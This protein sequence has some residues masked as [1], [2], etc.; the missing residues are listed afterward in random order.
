MDHNKEQLPA[1][2]PLPEDREI[3][4]EIR[5]EMGR[6]RQNISE[7]SRIPSG[8]EQETE[9]LPQVMPVRSVS[10]V[11]PV[12]NGDEEK[13]TIQPSQPP[14][15]EIPA[16]PL[17][18]PELPQ[19][20]APTPSP[21]VAEAE[22]EEEHPKRKK[23]E[24]KEK[25]EKHSRRKEKKAAKEIA[26]EMENDIY[27]GVRIRS[28]D[29]IKKD[30]E[31]N[32]PKQSEPTSTFTY[33]FDNTAEL[34]EILLSKDPE[35]L[36]RE[37]EERARQ[38]VQDA[39]TELPATN[40]P[41]DTTPIAVDKPLAPEFGHRQAAKPDDR[42][43][44]IDG[45]D[46][47]EWKR[48]TQQFPILTD[49]VLAAHQA[50][51]LPVSTVKP[52]N[53]DVLPVTIRKDSP[54]D[55]D[56]QAL[57]AF[58]E[59]TLSEPGQSSEPPVDAPV[60]T[61]PISSAE[62]NIPSESIP[63]TAEPSVTPEEPKVPEQPIVS[64]FPA[65]DTEPSVEP[66][67]TVVSEPA[68]ET[69]ASVVESATPE[70]PNVP[71]Q[72][73]PI[74]EAPA[75]ISVEPTLD[76]DTTEPA[77]PAHFI[78]VADPERYRFHSIPVRTYRLDHINEMLQ[79]EL[80]TYRD[81]NHQHRP[82]AQV[83][84]QPPVTKEPEN[85]SAYGKVLSLSA[86]AG[87]IEAAIQEAIRQADENQLHQ[88]QEHSSQPEQPSSSE[89][90]IPKAEPPFPEETPV[91][92]AE[93]KEEPVTS[94]APSEPEK[95]AISDA[96]DVPETEEPT[97]EPTAESEVTTEESVVESPAEEQP[98]KPSDE[99]DAQETPASEVIAEQAAVPTDA[100]PAPPA[101][102][103]S[104]KPEEPKA[105]P[106]DNEVTSEKSSSDTTESEEE[107]SSEESTAEPAAEAPAVTATEQPKEESRELSSSSDGHTEVITG[108]SGHT[109]LQ[110]LP[111]IPSLKLPDE[112]PTAPEEPKE[113]IC[114]DFSEQE[115]DPIPAGEEYTPD[116]NPKEISKE[117]RTMT[118]ELQIRT[119]VTGFCTAALL[120]L[121]LIYEKFIPDTTNAIP[122]LIINLVLLVAPAALCFKTIVNGI[123]SLFGLQG[124]TDS[125]IA[126]AVL[127]SIVHGVALFFDSSLVLNGSVH[128]Y[129]S[130]AVGALLLNSIGKLSMTNR[131]A[132]NFIFVTSAET[133]CSVEFYDNINT[134]IQLANGCVTEAPKIAYQKKTKFLKNFLHHSY[135]GDPSVRTSQ[136]I[137]PIALVASVALCIVTIIIT[138]NVLM[139]LTALSVAT[140]I[141][142]PLASLLCVNLPVA[143]LCNL[144]RRHGAMLS[145]YEAVE[146]MASANA[147][148][149]GSID[150]F[151]K[152]SVS[153]SDVKIYH[154]KRTE[155]AIFHAAA[156]MSNIG[157]TLRDLFEGVI[158][159]QK[160]MLPKA[161]D[162]SYI[163]GQGMVGTVNG[164]RL[165]IGTRLMMEENNIQ[166][167]GDDKRLHLKGN[168]C[169]LFLAEDEELMAM[170]TVSYKPDGATV[171]EL[172]RMERCGIAVLVRAL[173]PNLTSAFLTKLFSLH[174]NTIKV[175]PA[176][177]GNYCDEALEEPAESCDAL[178]A[179]RGRTFSMMRMLSACARQKHNISLTV[180]M[181][182]VSVILGFVLV[183]FLSCYAGLQQ[184]S[185][186]AILLYE[187]FWLAA[188]ILIPK[189]RKP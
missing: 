131:I 156:V 153:L 89:Q 173:D 59:Q 188:I 184:L 177:L 39:M 126:V 185:T 53:S 174:E 145:G 38:A 41:I 130:I 105:E 6:L 180:T 164:K 74:V 31:Q 14:Q 61:K 141:S 64:E 99:Q 115:K 129:S 170:L 172:H 68:A 178:L 37:R 66:E 90:E 17:P 132:R 147:V 62:L 22:P 101:E 187:A 167:P 162:I 171:H 5:S 94:P 157:G 154:G 158:T 140:C 47:K 76:V 72:A 103:A 19:T 63:E 69:T 57:E 128:L 55:P 29:E 80:E 139:G 52:T 181:Q 86:G 123:K 30:L 119:V 110:T 134:A 11:R 100:E 95:A 111:P 106:S 20:P 67:P 16:N 87:G 122:Y 65:A 160:E 109:G 73:A 85:Q 44:I 116:S 98:E 118:K 54:L 56:I 148:L 9:A 117:L 43:I 26:D 23:K 48:N 25:K 159:A 36:K 120:A 40:E 168:Q 189:L 176:E 133:K 93:S 8:V 138:G 42:P 104:E 83:T 149:L 183:A 186:L 1:I 12:R 81:P 113:P 97:S 152:D 121:G 4:D 175:L 142:A 10:E 108:T 88:A 112:T 179:T 21:E 135:D 13:P 166:L 51:E 70:L 75:E 155:R 161:T 125:G 50:G 71:E 35:E 58:M 137:A 82:V 27:Y 150:L 79:Q 165:R 18:S 127:A 114:P 92:A 136:L 28:Y 151:P 143:N 77:L 3:V 46:Y 34:P 33:L 163:E 49:E 84:K 144:A 15:P 124:N 60:A 96:N 2:S 45:F 24:K 102:S 182:I 91:S 146:K 107:Q 78:P 169:V 7:P 32:G